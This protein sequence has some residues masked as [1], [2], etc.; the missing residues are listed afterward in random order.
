MPLMCIDFVP[1]CACALSI[2]TVPLPFRLSIHRVALGA[3][4]TVPASKSSQNTAPEGQPV[5]A[6]PVPPLAPAD[7][8]VPP[9][10][11]APA[12]PPWPPLPP[13][14]ALLPPA[15]ADP[16]WPATPGV[17]PPVPP[18][19]DVARGTGRTGVARRSPGSG[20]ACARGSVASDATAG[21]GVAGRAPAS[22]C[23]GRSTL[24]ARARGAA[25]RAG[26][27]RR[28][29]GPTAGATRTGGHE[30][31]RRKRRPEARGEG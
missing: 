3:W 28:A 5:A 4:P 25:A 11:P 17:P 20:Y 15:P 31:R 9:R 8:V 14:P 6:P 16:P 30:E 10:P 23:P 29:P 12:D 1:P 13:R 27:T 2:W 26:G 24:P 19:P 21:A 22:R 7:P 18:R